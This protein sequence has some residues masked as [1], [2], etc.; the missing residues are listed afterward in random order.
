MDYTQLIT[1]LEQTSLFNLYRLQAGITRM[2]DQPDRVD[3][4]KRRLY[5]GQEITYFNERENRLIPAIVI[6]LRRTQLT[7]QNRSDGQ[8]WNIQFYMINIDQVETDI[9]STQNQMDRNRLKIGDQVGFHDNK[10]QEHHG[11]VVRLNPKTVTIQT[12]FATKWRVPYSF[13]FKVVDG[14]GQEVELTGLIEGEV[15]SPGSQEKSGLN[16]DSAAG[17]AR[18]E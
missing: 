9:Y 18:R 2:L 3:A 17:W 16:K 8:R 10:Q 4:I 13:D 6:E 14:D 15:L 1:E 5:P 7:V 11:E 12:K